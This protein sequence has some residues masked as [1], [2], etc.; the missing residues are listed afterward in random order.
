MGR[1]LRRGNDVAVR[2]SILPPPSLNSPEVDRYLPNR[3]AELIWLPTSLR[4]TRTTIRRDRSP[5]YVLVWCVVARDLRH[6]HRLSSG[7]RPSVK[8]G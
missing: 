2:L 1:T 6:D 5:G 7:I 8:L 3:S 4:P